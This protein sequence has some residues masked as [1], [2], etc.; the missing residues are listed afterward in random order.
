MWP[1]RNHQF[2]CCC[3]G[4]QQTWS[5]LVGFA[6]HGYSQSVLFGHVADVRTLGGCS[7]ACACVR[8]CGASAYAN[9][10]YW[11]LLLKLRVR[12]SRM[13]LKRSFH[14]CVYRFL[15]MLF[16]GCVLIRETNFRWCDLSEVVIMF[17]ATSLKWRLLS[18]L[19]T[20]L[21]Q[22]RW[23][24]HPF[25]NSWCVVDIV[26]VRVGFRCC[27]FLRYAFFAHC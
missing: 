18:V 14:V 19:R 8:C 10:H 16:K 26:Y 12:T 13:L 27:C 25:A 21:G 4:K 5:F 6:W 2:W 11:T 24:Q 3:R 17:W 7:L 20:C 1:K 23:G 9:D 22:L 15:L